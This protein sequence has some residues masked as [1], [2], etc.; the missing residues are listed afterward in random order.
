[1]ELFVSDLDG[2]LL[3]SKAQ[4]SE[5]SLEVINRL[6]DKGLNFTIATA[7][8]VNSASKILSGV[9]FK[10]PIIL[11]NGVLIYNTESSKYEKVYTIEK[12]LLKIICSEKDKY[13]VNG[14]MYTINRNELTA[15]YD[16]ISTPQMERSY[17]EGVTV[18]NKKYRQIKNLF[19]VEDDVIYF[20]FT[21]TKEKLEPLY[22]SLKKVEGLE[23]TF[24]FDIYTDDLWYLEI[25]SSDASKR[26]AVMYIRDKYNFNQISCFGDNTNDL[27]MFEISDHKYAV[28][29]ANEIVKQKCDKII[30]SNDNDGVAKLLITIEGN[31]NG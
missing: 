6:I 22:N 8:A 5:Y 27:P 23:I 1:M 4:L 13:D 12:E 9:N 7:R 20:A 17:N 10:L 30:D 31:L 29:N 26:N 14:F 24:Y 19:E 11:M 25:F 2:T 3:N 15:N 28:Q 21:N 18:Y 16:S